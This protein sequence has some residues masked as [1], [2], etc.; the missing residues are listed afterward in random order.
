M[1]TSTFKTAF[2]AFIISFAALD[3]FADN[4]VTKPSPT[5]EQKLEKISQIGVDYRP[6]ATVLLYPKGQYRLFY[7]E[8]KGFYNYGRRN[9]ASG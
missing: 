8:E 7:N 9:G 4:K 5:V 6:T 3:S 1:R 2:A